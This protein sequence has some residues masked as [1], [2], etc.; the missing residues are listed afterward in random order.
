ME[1]YI[2]K[3]QLT[4][5]LGGSLQYK[6]VQWVQYRTVSIIVD[7]YSTL[8]IFNVCALLT[9][10]R[11][12]TKW[13]DISQ[14]LFCIFMDLTSVSVHKNTKKNE[15]NIRDLDQTNLVSKG[16]IICQ[17]ITPKNFV[18]VRTK[19]AIPSGQDRPIL[20]ALVAN[21]NTGFASSCPLSEPAIY[22]KPTYSIL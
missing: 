4:E 6:H 8:D 7:L 3:S 10:K 9:M 22:N 16:F 18:F 12:R 5:E 21:Q 2:D 17:K 14:V 11:V 15:A 1:E 13:L 19:W 20:P